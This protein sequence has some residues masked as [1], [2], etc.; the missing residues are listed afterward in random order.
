MSLIERTFT[1]P[2]IPAATWA[3]L[4][5]VTAWPSWATHIRRVTLDPPGALTKTTRGRLLLEPGLPTTF[6]MTAFD[7][8]RSWSW[9]GAFA[10]TTLEYDHRVEALAGG[11]T[12]ITFAIE[13]SGP[14]VRVVG[15]IFA[16]MYGGILDRAIPELLAELAR[17]NA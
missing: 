13:G 16:R 14:T 10:G 11:G 4:S 6:R 17:L 8:P 15:P 3:H 2:A 1:T 5:N 12:R 9:R 7:P